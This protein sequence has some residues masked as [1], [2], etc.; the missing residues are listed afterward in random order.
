WKQAR[1]AKRHRAEWSPDEIRISENV[2]PKL[3]SALVKSVLPV[4]HSSVD[5]TKLEEQMLKLTG[6]GGFQT[7]SYEFLREQ[8]KNI[9]NIQVG[10]RTG[11]PAFLKP[12]LFVEGASGYGMRFGIGARITVLD[13][14]GPA[15]EWRTDLAIGTYNVVGTE[16]Y[17]RIHGGKWFVAPR[18]S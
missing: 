10:E 2:P 12:G 1:E 8:D 18:A 14:G 17:H 15:S 5:Q 6:T 3:R 11:G 4:A 13:V 7:A 9:L 16:Y